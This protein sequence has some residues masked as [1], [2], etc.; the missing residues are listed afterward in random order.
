MGGTSRW[1]SAP[2]FYL[3]VPGYGVILQAQAFGI[4]G[5]AHLSAGGAE[6]SEMVFKSRTM[7]ALVISVP[8]APCHLPRP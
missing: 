5:A 8:A 3:K 7:A 6:R 1:S 2:I 4:K